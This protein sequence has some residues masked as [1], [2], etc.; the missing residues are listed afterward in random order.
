MIVQVGRSW[1]ARARQAR[2]S[3]QPADSLPPLSSGGGGG[4]GF[5]SSS[6]SPPR[7][8]RSSTLQS[9]PRRAGGAAPGGGAGG[10]ALQ[11]FSSAREPRAAGS[12]LDQG[13]DGDA[14]GDDRSGLRSL[15]H[16]TR[17]LPVPSMGGGDTPLM[18]TVQEGRGGA[19]GRGAASSSRQGLPSGGGAAAQRPWQGPGGQGSVGGGAGLP[20]TASLPGD[21]F[22]SA[23]VQ[24]VR[25]AWLGLWWGLSGMPGRHRPLFH[26][27]KRT[28]T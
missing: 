11:Q 2:A 20:A 4:D 25:A 14:H 3:T 24:Q 9:P 15:E 26:R 19:A 27:A 5:R 13:L 16:T 21:P 22:A 1:A 28:R 6:A 12:A 10:R 7:L 8:P 17:L 23:A 18:G